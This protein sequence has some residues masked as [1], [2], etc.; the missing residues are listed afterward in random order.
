MGKKIRVE[1]E[2]SPERVKELIEKGARG[3]KRISDEELKAL[4]DAGVVR[5]ADY[6]DAAQLDRV[7]EAISGSFSDFVKKAGEKAVVTAVTKAAAEAADAAL[8]SLLAEG[9]RTIDDKPKE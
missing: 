9:I 5:A 3:Q 4:A 7:S 6:L 1:I 2:L 8:V